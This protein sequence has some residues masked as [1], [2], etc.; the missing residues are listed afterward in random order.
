M[1]EQ[2]EADAE[3]GELLRTTE[4]TRLRALVEA[5]IATADR[6]H[7]DDY[8]LT[9]PGGMRM[10]KAAYLGAIGDGTR[11]RIA[12][13]LRARV[14]GDPPRE[15]RLFQSTC[16]DGFDRLG[17]FTFIGVKNEPVDGEKAVRGEEWHSL[18][19]VDERMALRQSDA[20]RSGEAGERRASAVGEEPL[21]VS[22]A[23]A[24]SSM[25]A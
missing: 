5:D 8:Q 13:R 6:L 18:V 16:C 19:A 14:G 9:T 7:A 24:R 17:G 23:V 10:P 25:C 22:R 2:F 12:T 20:E 15:P 4:R 1:D 21:E 3:L 11:L